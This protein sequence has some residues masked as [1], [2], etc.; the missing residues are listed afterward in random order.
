ME[1]NKLSPQESIS[2]IEN[3]ISLTRESARD[4]DWYF[5]LFGILTI[6]CSLG[7]VLLMNMG[8]EQ[9]SSV[10]SLMFIGAIAAGIKGRKEGIK[11]PHRSRTDSLY[12]FIWLAFGLTYFTLILASILVPGIGYSIINPGVISLAGGATFL[13][14]I[15]MRFRAFTLGGIFMWLVAMASLNFDIQVQLLLNVV[16]IIGG[17]LIPAWMLRKSA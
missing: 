4:Q 12:G 1:K 6:I 2:I 15:L 16:A 11:H 3:M 8:Y 7:Q 10:W 5:F 9:A 13:S 14:G 17:Y